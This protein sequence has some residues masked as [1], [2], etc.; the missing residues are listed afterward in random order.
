M[1]LSAIQA[2]DM[3]EAWDELAS[4]SPPVDKGFMFDNSDFINKINSKIAE[5][6]D[7]HSGSSYGWTMRQIEYIAKNGAENYVANFN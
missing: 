4:Y 1:V 6:Y 3:L 2:I 7:G 5:L